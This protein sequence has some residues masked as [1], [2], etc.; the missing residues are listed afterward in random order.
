MSINNAVNLQNSDFTLTGAWQHNGGFNINSTSNVD[1][2]SLT[3]A[4]IVVASN[5]TWNL[6]SSGVLGGVNVGAGV[7]ID[8]LTGDVSMGTGSPAGTLLLGSFNS[9]VDLISATIMTLSSG[10]QLSLVSSGTLDASVSGDIT[11]DSSAGSVSIT[12]NTSWLG[13][14]SGVSILN[15]DLITG[16][17]TLSSITGAVAISST[18]ASITLTTGTDIILNP[19]GNLT[20]TIGSQASVAAPPAI[21]LP[22]GFSYVIREDA[23]GHIFYLS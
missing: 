3:Q 10:T 8:A 16:L 4:Q 21:S 22:A 18:P 12:G 1:I 15:M 2:L 20:A 19:T 23:T 5:A 14:K 6:S 11:L 7:Q 13:G 9:T 17:I